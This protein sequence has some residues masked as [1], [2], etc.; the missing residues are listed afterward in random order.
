M[1]NQKQQQRYSVKK[2][3]NHLS[4]PN[5][6]FRGFFRRD[7]SARYRC[8][9][10]KFCL[11]QRQSNSFFRSAAE[12]FSHVQE[13]VSPPSRRGPFETHPEGESLPGDAKVI[14][15]EFSAILSC[16]V[17]SLL[18]DCKSHRHRN[19]HRKFTELP[20]SKSC[21]EISILENR[22]F[23]TNDF[24]KTFGLAMNKNVFVRWAWH[25]NWF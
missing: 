18:D 25:K 13:S 17:A 15:L 3:I 12:N 22:I 2:H 10:D 1:W 19:V 21:Q 9:R 8:D 6:A 14:I 20:S 16:F 4:P 5:N 7:Q 23:L 11:H 24:S